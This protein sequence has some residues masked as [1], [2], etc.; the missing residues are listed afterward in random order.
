[1]SAAIVRYKLRS[2]RVDE[3][4]EF[5]RSVFADL[6][7]RRP[8]GVHYATFQAADEGSFTHVAVFESDEARAAFGEAA[9]FREFTADIAE[10]CVEPPTAVAQTVVGNYRMVG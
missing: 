8:P 3:N 2:D 10:R 9:P 6:D 4:V 7:A 1:M 5:V